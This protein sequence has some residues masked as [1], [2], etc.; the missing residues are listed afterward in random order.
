[1]HGIGALKPHYLGPWTFRVKFMAFGVWPG[2][3]V[4]VT[5]R[6]VHGAHGCVLDARQ[7]HIPIRYVGVLVPS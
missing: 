2:G 5:E 4:E 7:A 6:M 1:M 3:F